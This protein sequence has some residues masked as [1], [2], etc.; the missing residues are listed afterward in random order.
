MKEQDDI[1]KIYLYAK[2]LC[3]PKN[4][5]LSVQIQWMTFI[6]ILMTAIQPEKEKC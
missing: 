1:D 2:N 4:K 3:E 5:F 6:R